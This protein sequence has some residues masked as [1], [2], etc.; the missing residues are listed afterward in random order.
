MIYYIIL[1]VIST[2]SIATYLYIEKISKSFRNTYLTKRLSGF[3]VV[4]YILDKN[5]IYI[6]EKKSTVTN[7]YDVEHNVVR[8]D[9]KTFNGESIFYAV[10]AAFISGYV[11]EKD[12]TIPKLYNMF[13]KIIYF[14]SIFGI[15]STIIGTLIWKQLFYIGVT[16]LLLIFIIEVIS[17][18]FEVKN[19]SSTYELIKEEKLATESGYFPLFRYNP[20]TKEFHLDSK[21]DFSKYE[22]MFKNENRYRIVSDLLEQN[23]ENAIRNYEEL[24]SLQASKE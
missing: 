17:L 6:V 4:K 3:D 14:G 9:S 18:I 5:D 7:E 16:V 23:K 19:A 20:A 10:K 2:V 24:E 1:A 21:A 8:L 13:D 15:L 12:K 11:L 22:E